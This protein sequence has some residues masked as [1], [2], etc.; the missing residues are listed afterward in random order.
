MAKSEIR[1]QLTP[2]GL[3]QVLA[4]FRTVQR[5][6]VN[7]SS[8]SRAGVEGLRTA[9]VRLRSVLGALG[10]ATSIAGIV[11]F[12]IAAFK[13]ARE[14]VEASKQVNI[15][16]REYTRLREAIKATKG[17]VEA[18]DPAIT[19]LRSNLSK[20]LSDPD[21]EAARAFQQLRIDAEAFAKLPL[22]SQIALIADK[23]GAL[24]SEED[25]LRATQDLLGRGADGL[26]VSFRNGG[27]ALIGFADD[28]QRAGLI[29]ENDVAERIDRAGEAVDRLKKK[30]QGLT[31][32]GLA[33]VSRA[34]VAGE[35]IQSQIETLEARRSALRVAAFVPALSGP[36][37]AAIAL[38]NS[39]L[40]ELIKKQQQLQDTAPTTPPAAAP[41][42][43]PGE[44]QLAFIE[45][46][47]QRRTRLAVERERIAEEIKLQEERN[48]ARFEADQA[49]YDRGL[50]SLQEFYARRLELT[51]AAAAAEIEALERQ[52]A[53]VQAEPAKGVDEQRRRA[54]ESD[55]IRNEIALRRLQTETKIGVLAAEQTTEQ[56]RLDEQW[57]QTLA[58]LDEVEGRRHESFQRNLAAEILAIEEL[59]RKAGQT[60]EQIATQTSRFGA[61]ST[62]RFNFEEV[63]RKGREA[64]EAFDRDAQRIQLEQ[65]AGIITQLEGENRL[66]ALQ[67]QR[68]VVLQ[69]LAAA[70]LAA[71]RATQTE[72]NPLGDPE[73]IARAEQFAASVGQIELSFIAATNAAGR[74]RQ[75]LETGLQEGFIDLFTNIDEINSLEDAFRSLAVTVARSLAQ[76]AAEILAKQATFALLRAFGSAFGI[77]SGASAPGG[78]EG[79]VVE[80]YAGGGKVRGRRL[81]IRGPDKVPALLQE[82]E[83]VVRRSVA[84]RPGMLQVL[85]ELNAA[86][87]SPS[88]IMQ[89]LAIKH[90]AEG[91]PVNLAAAE[92]TEGTGSR[93]GSAGLTGV[94]GLEDGL[95]F[96]QLS[97]PAFEELLVKKIARN[98]GMFRSAL[99]L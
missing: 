68:L 23:I 95:I 86:R 18:L 64:L 62:S 47:E 2:E 80:G 73:L 59:G 49:A 8:R 13:S 87:I 14:V 42:A 61:A 84:S 92:A 6:S 28:A 93:R 50:I 21:S 98:P 5:E 37:S 43:V 46:P 58:R 11:Q 35:D 4:A 22:E 32:E 85:R 74:L 48:K 34:L 44:G 24:D 19:K 33:F 89:P 77:G 52:L 99:G 56:R 91:G 60:A 66:I 10:I 40:D 25:R 72:A 78:F 55:K 41:P 54:A 81:N 16:A 79:G 57:N 83:F 27:T 67:Q 63:E 94:L 65:E 96:K 7:S 53:L 26:V 20:A 76:I 36:A 29:L 69:Q 9:V 38:I 31:T 15:S 45:T 39:Q 70:T 12:G 30:L 88:E 1:V 90:F 71:A 17:D 75:G 51:R 3:E 82:G 97:A